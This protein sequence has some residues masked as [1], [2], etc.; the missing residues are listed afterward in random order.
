[1]TY[2]LFGLLWLIITTLFTIPILISQNN[3]DIFLILFILLFWAIGI[4]FVTKGI[5]KI[6]TNRKTEKYGEDCFG[7][8]KNIYPNGTMINH[9]PMYNIDVDVY[10]PSKQTM[11]TITE[12]IGMDIGKYPLESIVKIKYYNNDINIKE[13]VDYN[14]IPLKIREYFER[15]ES[16]TNTQTTNVN[17]ST[18]VADVVTI[19][20][21]QYKRMDS[22][23]PTDLDNEKATDYETKY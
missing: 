17:T 23:N 19:N 21:V 12:E 18:E 14:S 10:I 11:I 22:A 5:K 15:Y 7:R 4:F 9:R 3:L 13:V 6:I 8:V 2:F 1:M 20:G 16:S